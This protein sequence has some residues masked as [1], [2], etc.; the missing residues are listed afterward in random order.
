MSESNVQPLEAEEEA[1]EFKS[2]SEEVWDTLSRIDVDDHVKWL[3]KTDKRPSISYLPW[4]KAWMLLKRR[5][6][7]SRYKHH[8]DLRHPDGTVE[9]SV[10]VIIKR[11]Q[12]AGNEGY[13]FTDATLAVMDS[14]FNPISNPNGRQVNDSRQRVLVKALAFAG[15]GLHLWGDDNVPVGE[16]E[17]PI[18]AEMYNSLMKL[19][20]ST[21]TNQEKFLEW[22]EVDDLKDLPVERYNSARGLLEAKARR[23]AKQS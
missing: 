17:D 11:D 6:P 20:E 15:L 16:L 10:Q 1:T 13:V 5:F 7:A 2:F 3:P 14:W 18:D 4:H 21:K 8:E 23:Q 9:V 19:I 22:C 12:A